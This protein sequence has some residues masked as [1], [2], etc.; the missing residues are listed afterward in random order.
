MPST[1]FIPETAPFSEEQR[2][3][4]NGYLAG[5]YSE[6]PGGDAPSATPATPVTL[7][8]GSQTGTAEGLCKKAAKQL[9]AVNCDPKIVDMS[10][11]SPDELAGVEH[12]LIIT[13]TYGEGD[14]PD[15]AQ[16]LH[17]ALMA[18]SAPKM[19]GVNYSVMGLGDT[20]YVDFCKCSKEF[21]ARLEGLGATRIAPMFE[22]DGDPDE[23]FAEWLAAVKSVLGEAGAAAA[24][25]SMEAPEDDGPQFDKK[26]PFSAKLL[27]TE[28]LNKAGSSKATHHVEISLE[29]SD[30]DYEV[31]DALGVYPE[32]NARLCDEIIE[33]AGFAPDELAPVPHGD[34]QPLFEALRYH[35]DVSVLTKAFRLTENDNAPAIMIGPGTGIAPFRAFL[36]EREARGAPGKNWLLFGDQHQAT[37]F[38]YEDQITAWM[39]SGLLTRFDTAFS[40]DQAEKVYVQDRILE[41]AEE[42]YAWLEDGGHIYICGDASR[43]A[44]DVDKAIHKAIETAAGKSEDEAKAYVD[45]LKKAKRYLR[46]VY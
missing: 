24:E 39:K 42:F 19:E 22:A 7:L 38:L 27:K 18:E 45:A 8:F 13:S 11:V 12:L 15:N 29:G 33:A 35:Y 44:K 1:P 36:E 4:L 17:T 28:N 40:R 30:L 2:S 32:N 20:N 21:D 37:D 43:M 26:H 34:D 46:D 5:L 23:P 16:A 3:W 41:L 25:P 10:E 14:P 6:A 9:K 31:G